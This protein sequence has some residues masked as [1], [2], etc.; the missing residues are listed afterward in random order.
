MINEKLARFRQMRSMTADERTALKIKSI[1]KILRMVSSAERAEVMFALTRRQRA[2]IFWPVFFENWP[3]CDDT[4][5]VRD[6]LLELLQRCEDEASG[7]DFLPAEARAA[8]EALPDPA[9]VFRGA[10]REK[11]KG[12]SWTTDRKIAAG[13]AHGHRLIEVADP[14]IA[15]G[16]V[17]KWAVYGVCTDRGEADVVL[18]PQNVDELEFEEFVPSAEHREHREL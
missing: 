7:L 12:I 5:C 15:T 17:P 10:E 9:R 6:G 2:E 4:W 8:Y 3:N 18:D 16:L 13:F 1:N 14:V 11:I